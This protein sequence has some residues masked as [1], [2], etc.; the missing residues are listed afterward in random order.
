MARYYFHAENGHRVVD[1]QGSDYE[2]DVEVR[3]TALRLLCEMLPMM[4][5]DLWRGRAARVL[6]TNAAQE[7]VFV[8]TVEASARGV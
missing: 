8:L 4:E 3:H 6:V 5:Q 1:E 2:S 7:E